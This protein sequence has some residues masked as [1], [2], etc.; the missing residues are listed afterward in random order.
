MYQRD[1]T[2]AVEVPMVGRKVDEV[3]DVG[4]RKQK[5][6][7]GHVYRQPH[8]HLVDMA[9]LSLPSQKV[10]IVQEP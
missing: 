10:D 2:I 5:W 1:F 9:L 6:H 7:L 4:R 3:I 8:G